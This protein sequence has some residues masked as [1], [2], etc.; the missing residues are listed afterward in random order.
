[1]RPTTKDLLEALRNPG[2]SYEALAARLPISMSTVNRWKKESPAEWDLYIELLD[3]AGWLNQ[4][5]VEGGLVAARLAADDAHR[6]A[7]RLAAE[8]ERPARARRKR[9]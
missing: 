4:D 2:E 7:D 8:N 1:V 6:R 9:A 3:R 5:R